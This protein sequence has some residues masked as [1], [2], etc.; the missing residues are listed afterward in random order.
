MMLGNCWMA[1]DGW[2]ERFPSKQAL[3]CMLTQ[4]Y[5]LSYTVSAYK[6]DLYIG[7][8]ATWPPGLSLPKKE[9]RSQIALS[10]TAG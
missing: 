2:P 5:N 6:K 10:L 8:I 4:L 9:V 1:A 7:D 3:I